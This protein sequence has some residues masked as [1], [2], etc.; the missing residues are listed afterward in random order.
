MKKRI[1]LGVALLGSALL[2]VSLALFGMGAAA[3][4]NPVPTHQADA[5]GPPTMAPTGGALAAPAVGTS[6]GT[7]ALPA[8]AVLPGA[9]ET[10][11]AAEAPGAAETPDVSATSASASTGEDAAIVDG[12]L[13]AAAFTALPPDEQANGR[14]WIETMTI[15]AAC[16]KQKG[17]I[18]T[19]LPYWERHS[20]ELPVMWEETLPASERTAARLA[21]NGNSGGGADY[22][23]EDAGCWGQAVHVMGNDNAH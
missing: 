1:A 21:L 3:T 18:Y 5:A 7:A 16:M 4:L 23:W 2:A 15:T 19:F 13:R 12:W 6:A 17:Y 11:G 14:E 22:H 8:P 9:A 20:T 10:A